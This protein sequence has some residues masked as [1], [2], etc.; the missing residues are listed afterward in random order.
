MQKYGRNRAVIIPTLNPVFGIYDSMGGMTLKKAEGR[1]ENEEPETG[2]GKAAGY[3][4]TR[5]AGNALRLV[6]RCGT[7]PPSIG[8]TMNFN[9]LD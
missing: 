4:D 1:V 7:Q 2:K 8:A 9:E 6:P 5:V 3:S